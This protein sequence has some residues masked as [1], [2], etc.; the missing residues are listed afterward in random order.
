MQKEK[1]SYCWENHLSK[2]HNNREFSKASKEYL[3]K[4]WWCSFCYSWL[5]LTNIHN[6]IQVI[7]IHCM[8]HMARPYDAICIVKSSTFFMN[9]NMKHIT[10]LFCIGICYIVQDSKLRKIGQN[11][12]LSRIYV[13]LYNF[14][15]SLEVYRI[16]WD[17]EGF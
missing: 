5:I 10:R 15:T 2:A 8:Y 7:I 1:G 12:F 11:S 14:E 16:W 9:T 4:N 17:I 6:Y 3:I 13:T